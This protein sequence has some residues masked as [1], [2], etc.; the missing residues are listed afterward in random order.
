MLLSALLP[1]T[2]LLLPLILVCVKGKPALVEAS[3]G[4]RYE[5]LNRPSDG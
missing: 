4:F 5:I 2:F 1:F 3:A